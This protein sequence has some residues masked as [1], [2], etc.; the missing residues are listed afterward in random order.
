MATFNDIALAVESDI[1][2]FS[3]ALLRDGEEA[4]DVTQDVL[5]KLWQH[6]EIREKN[7]AKRWVLRVARNA[8]LDRIKHSNVRIAHQQNVE[9]HHADVNTPFTIAKQNQDKQT[10][11]EAV[12]KLVEP[13]RS[14]VIL[15]DL[16]QFSYKEISESLDLS[17]DQVKVYLHRARKKLHRLLL[18]IT[19]Y[20]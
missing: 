13:Q 8:C 20:E 9:V 3:Y 14:I 18:G 1:F 17:Q 19:N 4:K 6:K 10:V 5:I 12:G 7:T 2:A 15:R 16:Q 11:L